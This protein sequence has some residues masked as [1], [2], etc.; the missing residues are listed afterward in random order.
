MGAWSE[1]PLDNDTAMD[2]VY[3]LEDKAKEEQFKN[4]SEL[5]VADCFE[6]L[7]NGPEGIE[8]LD[9]ENWAIEIL[10]VAAWLK[11][12]HYD[13][14]PFSTLIKQAIDIAII[15]ANSDEIGWEEPSDRIKAMIQFREELFGE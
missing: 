9:Q 7:E 13:F 14:K 4:N 3:D 5:F 11:N 10:A 8:I 15:N 1:G 12:H 6:C 2:F